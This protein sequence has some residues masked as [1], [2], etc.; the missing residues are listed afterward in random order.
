MPTKHEPEPQRGTNDLGTDDFV[1]VFRSEKDGKFYGEVVAPRG[2]LPD[3][4]TETLNQGYENKSDL[5]AIVAKHHGS[6]RVQD[7]TH[8][9]SG[10]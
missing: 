6:L 2:N 8:P 10:D 7:E 5:L 9:A 3:E 1:R 4:S